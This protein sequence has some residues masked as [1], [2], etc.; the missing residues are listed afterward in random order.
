MIPDCVLQKK[1]RKNKMD[2]KRWLLGLLQA[3]VIVALLV[4]FS[5]FMVALL[6]VVEAGT[7]ARIELLA[8][9]VGAVAILG[10]LFVSGR[11]LKRN[12]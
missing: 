3:V 6:G 9:A 12:F 10:H 4:G 2:T 7:F 5:V 1:G 8:A 11:Q